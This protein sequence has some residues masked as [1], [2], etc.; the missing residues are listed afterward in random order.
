MPRSDP[1]QLLTLRQAATLLGVHRRT[2]ERLIAAG[3]LQ[4][5][6]FERTSR[7]YRSELERFITAHTTRAPRKPAKTSVPRPSPTPMPETARQD[8]T[9]APG[10]VPVTHRSIVVLEDDE[11]IRR[12]LVYAL[13]AEG[14]VVRECASYDELLE[15][16]EQAMPDLILTDGWSDDTPTLTPAE[17]EAI[18]EL[19]RRCPTIMMTGRDWAGR[20]D[21][22]ELGLVALIRKPFELEH[23]LL[24]MRSLET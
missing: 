5:C 1:L 24:T 15:A 3:E 13:R 10:P 7:V 2:V 17:R 20:V 12:F 16:C 18:V 19:A 21:P 11:N 4:V 6:K 9:E 8:V 14:Y 22:A 23:L